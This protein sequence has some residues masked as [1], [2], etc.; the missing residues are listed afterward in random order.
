MIASF[1]ELALR[2]MPSLLRG[3]LITI[4]ISVLSMI[5]AVLIGLAVALIRSWNVP[6]L[7]T[8]LGFYVE[9]WRATPLVVQL[10]ILYFSL[11]DI[12][13][14]L[15]AFAAGV[16]GLSLNLGAY[17]SEVFRAAITSIDK[18]QTQAGLA[19]GLTKWLTF[20]K[21]IL[22]QALR[23]SLPTL[24]GYFISLLKDSS[25]VSFISINDLLRQGTIE[26]ATTFRTMEIYIIV[27]F[28]YCILSFTSSKLSK[29]IEFRLTPEYQRDVKH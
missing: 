22:P 9:I 27:A 19:L 15:P 26:I 2:I 7:S 21:I 25:L 17:L 24:G 28:I 3:T 13:I 1:Y 20:Y 18:G 4:E 5:F 8:V 12:G 6:V 29:I 16:I 23:I 11:P 10:L 14:S